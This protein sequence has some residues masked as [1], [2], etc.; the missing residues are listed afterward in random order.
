MPLTN[1]KIKSFLPDAQ[2]KNVNYILKMKQ[3]YNKTHSDRSNKSNYKTSIKRKPKKHNSLRVGSKPRNPSYNEAAE[4]GED[5]P[6]TLN[7]KE[8]NTY[9][10]DFNNTKVWDLEYSSYKDTDEYKELAK[11]NPSIFPLNG[12]FYKK[13]NK[14]FI[15]LLMKEEN[16]GFIGCL[17]YYLHLKTLVKDSAGLYPIIEMLIKHGFN[18][19]YDILLENNESFYLVAFMAHLSSFGVIEN[20]NDFL[21]S[22]K[23]NELHK[24]LR[25]KDIIM[26]LQKD[27]LYTRIKRFQLAPK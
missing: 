11:I 8:F 19:V 15:A 9:M 27:K 20:A 18:T 1:K 21:I 4:E 2:M 5:E 3:Q 26:Q 22:L 14:S 24:A 13:Y 23:T 16:V 6:L 7:K 10:L 17:N 12:I 25:N